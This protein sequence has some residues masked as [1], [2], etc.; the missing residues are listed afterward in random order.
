MRTGAGRRGRSGRGSFSAEAGCG[1]PGS[2]GEELP[3]RPWT[4]VTTIPS[5]AQLAC[6][7]S[8]QRFPVR[9][10]FGRRVSGWGRNNPKNSSRNNVAF[11]SQG[12]RAEGDTEHGLPRAR[13]PLLDR[14]A[15]AA[16]EWQR[17]AA[18]ADPAVGPTG[19]GPAPAGPGHDPSRT[20]DGAGRR[21]AARPL[22]A[23]ELLQ[24]HARGVRTRLAGRPTRWRRWI[25]TS[26][27]STRAGASSTTRWRGCGDGPRTCASSS[28][29]RRADPSRRTSCRPTSGPPTATWR[30]C[31]RRVGR[32]VGRCG[33]GISRRRTACR[34]SPRRCGTC[35]TRCA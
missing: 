28:S 25:P 10:P 27:W 17:S 12:G 2:V 18:Q 14:P 23:G 34:R 32:A 8:Q 30:D 20:F 3:Q 9:R 1:G 19:A 11:N 5:S 35:S 22:D 16:G 26:R 6:F 33:P 21:P 24:V 7:F 15:A 13:D 4:A 31:G 29:G